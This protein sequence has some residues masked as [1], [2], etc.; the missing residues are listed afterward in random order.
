MKKG[1]RLV[2]CRKGHGEWSVL[3]NGKRRCVECHRERQARWRAGQKGGGDGAVAAVFVGESG[4]GGV[5]AVVGGEPEVLG[6]A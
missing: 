3:G 4:G 2:A 6:E 5:G 1:E